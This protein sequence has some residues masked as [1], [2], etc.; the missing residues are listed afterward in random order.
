MGLFKSIRTLSRKAVACIVGTA[1]AASGAVAM[2]AGVPEAKAAETVPQNLSFAIG[3]RNYNMVN[4]GAN[5]NSSLFFTV[6]EGSTQYP[7]HQR[8]AYCLDANLHAPGWSDALLNDANWRPAD[9]SGQAQYYNLS[10][11]HI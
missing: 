3:L 6:K 11:I 9:S 10:L 8:A 4:A 1:M 5:S 7:Y 2:S